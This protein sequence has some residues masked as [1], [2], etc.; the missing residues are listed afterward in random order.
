MNKKG[1]VFKPSKFWI[2]IAGGV[3]VVALILT[4]V[5][6]G[7]SN[8][9]NKVTDAQNKAAFKRYVS[10][11]SQAV[12]E[13]EFGRNT[14]SNLDLQAGS[15]NMVYG[16]AL[17]HPESAKILNDNVHSLSQKLSEES[18]SI[19][20][21][22]TYD[23]SD[24]CV[25]LFKIKYKFGCA[26]FD[27]NVITAAHTSGADPNYWTASGQIDGWFQATFLNPANFKPNKIKFFR[28]LDCVSLKE[29]GCSYTDVEGLQRACIPQNNN[30]GSGGGAGGQSLVWFH[31]E[32]GWASPV[33]FLA[34]NVKINMVG[35]VITGDSSKGGALP[36]VN[37]EMSPDSPK[38]RTFGSSPQIEDYSSGDVPKLMDC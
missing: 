22:C 29:S 26:N 34:E 20:E 3:L 2:E 27:F 17:V 32:G 25:C 4:I 18:R 23:P 19:V 15:D 16:I 6:L 12:A 11:M 9:S 13:G 37:F 5:V 36:R 10:G 21:P 28:I 30:F 1:L 14:I 33:P 35:G 38:P 31:S 24:M 8:V 7:V